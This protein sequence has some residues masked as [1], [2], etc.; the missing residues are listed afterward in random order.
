MTTLLHRSPGS[1]PLGN[2]LIRLP[3]VQHKTGQCKTV[4]YDGMAAGTFPHSIPIGPKSV[5]WLEAEID[6]WIV[7]RLAERASRIRKA[8]KARDQSAATNRY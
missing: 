2:R 6:Q 5:A 7:D 4:I 8:Q 3:E 1:L